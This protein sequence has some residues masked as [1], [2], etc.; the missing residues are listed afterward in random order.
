MY[1]CLTQEMYKLPSLLFVC[2]T[3]IRAAIGGVKLQKKLDSLRLPLLLIT[4][5]QLNTETDNILYQQ[6]WIQGG[7][8]GGP[9]P[10]PPDHQK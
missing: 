9:G 6:G 10:D 4:Y 5:L 8:S 1:E 3:V 7:G 2:R